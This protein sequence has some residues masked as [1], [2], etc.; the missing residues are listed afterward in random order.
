M[1]IY[2][3]KKVFLTGHSGFKGT[4]LYKILETIG[5]D[6]FGYSLAPII[7]PN[8]FDLLGSK[9]S[10]SGLFADIRDKNSLQNTLLSFNPHIIFHLAAQPLVRESY[11][12]PYETFEINALGILNLLYIV[13]KIKDQLSNLKAIVVITT[14]KVYENKEWIWGYRENDRLGGFD[15]YSASK[16]CG[17]IVVDSMRQSFFNIADFTILHNILIATA[18]AGNVIGGGDFSQDRLLPDLIRGVINKKPT[19][20]R[21]PYSTR[22]WQSVLEP[23]R[24]YLLLGKKLL[25]GETKFASSFNFGPDINGNLKVLEMLEIAKSMWNKINYEIQED[26]INPHEANLLMLDTSKAYHLLQY[27]PILNTIDS[28]EHT[29]TWYKKFVEDKEIITQKQIIE[30]LNGGGESHNLNH[31]NT[32]KNT[33]KNKNHT[34]TLNYIEILLLNNLSNKYKINQSKHAA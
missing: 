31:K 11:K 3:N 2:K 4:W 22:P 32:S 10:F 27:K 19:I 14:D 33:S 23:L 6:V 25:Q 5:S 21:N 26:S 12:N 1:N 18:R 16:A 29:I 20:I 15:P 8:H 13:Y 24:G 17:E 28:I 30:Y 9:D 34:K 7:T